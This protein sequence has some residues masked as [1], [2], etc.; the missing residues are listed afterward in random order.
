MRQRLDSAKSFFSFRIGLPYFTTI[1][2]LLSSVPSIFASNE[3]QI[4]DL[5]EELRIEDAKLDNLM[6]RLHELMPTN[7]DEEI[8]EHEREYRIQ[9]EVVQRIK[10]QIIALGGT[11]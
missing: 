3:G 9:F 1:C 2:L 7:H 8:A 6:D 5:Q 10:D 11:Y 4:K